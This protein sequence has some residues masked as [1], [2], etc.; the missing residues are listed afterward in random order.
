VV[1]FQKVYNNLLDKMEGK[2]TKRI[3]NGK[4]Y[5]PLLTDSHPV[6]LAEFDHYLT[7][8]KTLTWKNERNGKI[9]IGVPNKVL[10]HIV[11]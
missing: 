5:C 4:Y 3:Y 9:K 7:S 8:L 10:K 6:I 2:R 1:Q 11:E